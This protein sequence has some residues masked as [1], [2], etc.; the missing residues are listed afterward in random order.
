MK[1]QIML[2]QFESWLGLSCPP[3]SHFSRFMSQ[4]HPGHPYYRFTCQTLRR[5]KG[6]IR[7]LNCVISIRLGLE[8]AWWTRQGGR[9]ERE[10]DREEE[11]ERD[12]QPFTLERSSWLI[13]LATRP[14]STRPF[15]KSLTFF[16]KRS[17]N[18]FT[19]SCE[20]IDYFIFGMVSYC[21]Q[22]F[23]GRCLIILEYEA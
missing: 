1:P 23:H 17:T 14:H 9:G 12:L 7:I 21:T 16:G 2:W 18:L 8:V 10:R 22:R 5:G 19:L 13:S 11:H 3:P 4:L 20:K 15:P 6:W